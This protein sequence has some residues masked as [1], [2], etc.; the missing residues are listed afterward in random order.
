MK[1]VWGKPRLGQ[2]IICWMSI[3]SPAFDEKGKRLLKTFKQWVEE[4]EMLY[5]WQVIA[6]FNVLPDEATIDQW[7]TVLA[8]ARP[9]PNALRRHQDAPSLSVALRMR[10]IKTLSHVPAPHSIVN[11]GFASNGDER[12]TPSWTASLRADAV[13]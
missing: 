11:R 5:E 2:T 6:R 13:C 9:P 1:C 4:M 8:E 12:A 7:Y 3:E 10:G